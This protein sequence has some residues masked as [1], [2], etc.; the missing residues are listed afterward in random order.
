MHKVVAG[1]CSQ[2]CVSR[3]IQCYPQNVASQ[4][5][6]IDK[7]LFCLQDSPIYNTKIDFHMRPGTVQEKNSLDQKYSNDFSQKNTKH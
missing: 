3:C 1:G 4:C 7:I 6:M 5:A 2:F